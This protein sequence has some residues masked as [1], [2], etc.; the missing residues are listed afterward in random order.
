MNSCFLKI[1]SCWRQLV[2]RSAVCRYYI[3]YGRSATTRTCPCVPNSCSFAPTHQRCYTVVIR[4]LTIATHENSLTV[5]KTSSVTREQIMTVKNLA[6]RP[7]Q[8]SSWDSRTCYPSRA[9]NQGLT[10]SCFELVF[11]QDKFC[12]KTTTN[13]SF[14]MNFSVDAREHSKGAV[15]RYYISYGRSFQLCRESDAAVVQVL[16]SLI[17]FVPMRQRKRPSLCSFRMVLFPSQG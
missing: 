4:E 8:T 1:N 12:P 10:N 13:D 3:S 5:R 6:A 2:N 15:C 16:E 14:S 11:S 9:T 17:K 7:L